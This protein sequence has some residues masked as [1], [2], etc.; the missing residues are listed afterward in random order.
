VI[1]HKTQ[2]LETVDVPKHVGH[3]SVNVDPNIGHVN[4]DPNIV[5]DASLQ[6]PNGIPILAKILSHVQCC[7]ERVASEWIE[8]HD[9]IKVIIRDHLDHQR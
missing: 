2:I 6:P 3:V 8:K 4:V 9:H 7:L 1:I 5:M